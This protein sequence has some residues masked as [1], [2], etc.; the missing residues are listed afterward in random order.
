MKSDVK[1]TGN[2]LQ[3]TRVFDASRE[4]V[5]AAW[6]TRELLQRWSGCKETTRNDI[7]LDFRVGGTFTHKMQIDGA[8]EHT[9]R[10]VYD[11]I[12]EPEKIVPVS[13]GFLGPGDDEVMVEFFADGNKT[14]DDFDAGRISRSGCV[15]DCFAGD[16]GGTG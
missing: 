5:F 9:I 4:R 1:I 10:G 15:Q 14:K 12:I 2:H 13:R 11:E 6:K 7:E 16:N 8:G 3:I